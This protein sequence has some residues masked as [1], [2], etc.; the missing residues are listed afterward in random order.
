M[1]PYFTITPLIPLRLS[2]I[3]HIKILYKYYD[4]LIVSRITKNFDKINFLLTFLGNLRVK[5]ISVFYDSRDTQTIE[6]INFV[7]KF[8]RVN[9]VCANIYYITFTKHEEQLSL[10]VDAKYSSIFMFIFENYDLSLKMINFLNKCSSKHQVIIYCKTNWSYGKKTWQ[11]F[12]ELRFEKIANI[13]FQ[14]FQ[15]LSIR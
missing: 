15:L 8:L 4:N 14:I 6:E 5:L 11:W 9:N 1:S 7:N 3:W 12:N 2:N 13:C 10:L